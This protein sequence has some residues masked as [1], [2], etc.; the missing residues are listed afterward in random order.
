MKPF[1]LLTEQVIL[2][3]LKTHPSTV[4]VTGNRQEIQLTY[5]DLIIS[6]PVREHIYTRWICHL[7]DA[8]VIHQDQAFVVTPIIIKALTSAATNRKPSSFDL[9]FE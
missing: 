3:D 2:E 8:K 6:F 5:H 9:R 7:D 1:H 4:K